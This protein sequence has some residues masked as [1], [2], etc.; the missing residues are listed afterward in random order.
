M[1]KVSRRRSCTVPL[2]PCLL[3]LLMLLLVGLFAAPFISCARAEGQTLPVPS[4][5]SDV[6]DFVAPGYP[7]YGSDRPYAGFGTMPNA[8]L[9]FG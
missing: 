9:V 6:E 1:R 8:P 2:F 5:A 7:L 3:A 4:L